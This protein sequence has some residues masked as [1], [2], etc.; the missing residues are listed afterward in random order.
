MMTTEDKVA[1]KKKAASAVKWSLLTEVLV[2]VITPLTQIILAHILAPEAFGVVATVTMV[3]SFADMLSDAGFQK[4][5]VQ[6]DFENLESLFKTADV[7]F[8][9][10]LFVSL[11]LWLIILVFNDPIA[12]SVGCSGLGSVLIFASASL[13]LTA[14]SS[15]QLAIFHREFEFKDLLVSRV[16]VALVPMV[17]TVPLAFLGFSYWSL[18]IGTVA[19]NL[20]NALVLTKM[21]KWRPKA[22]YSLELLKDML[23]FSFWTLLESISIWLT[24]W[25]GTFVLGSTLSTYYLGLYKTSTGMVNA[26]MGIVTS[27]TTPIL[28]SALSR[29][30][31]DEESFESVFFDMQLKVALFVVPLGVGIYVFRR[32]VTDLLMGPNWMESSDLLGLWGLSSSLVI[33]L[34][35]YASEVFRAKGKPKLS[36]ANQCLYLC[37]LIPSM[38]FSA[39]MGFTAFSVTVCA[40]RVL[41][42]GIGFIFLGFV[43]FP[44]GKMLSNILST[45]FCS[46]VMGIFGTLLLEFNSTSLF[47]VLWILLCMVIYAALS[48]IF[49]KTR[50]ILVRYLRY[51]P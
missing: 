17:I 5:L 22:F 32:F 36:F 13:P 31:N 23:G 7:A 25:V 30:Q 37:I 1:I 43:A 49:P 47:C 12:R 33:I 40:V 29:Y 4:Y 26:A 38:L 14:L 46:L 11:V 15:I 19:G 8:W 27:A 9:T 35:H 28:F 51:L 48:L 18:V 2:K 10:N 50:K 16:S 20:V 45:V 34:S 41:G 39:Q 3:V 24:S 21:S 6:H 42:I 44:V